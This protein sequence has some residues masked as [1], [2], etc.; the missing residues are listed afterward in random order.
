[1]AKTNIVIKDYTEHFGP[2]LTAKDSV[3][4]SYKF[5]DS[6]QFDQQYEGAP[7]KNILWDA[8]QIRKKTYEDTTAGIWIGVDTDGKAKI[9][10]GDATN[11]FVWN[12]TG[13]IITGNTDFNG[14]FSIVDDGEL[15]VNFNGNYNSGTDTITFNMTD[16]NAFNFFQYVETAGTSGSSY[17]GGWTQT[18]PG[19]ITTGNTVKVDAIITAKY[20]TATT[21]GGVQAIGLG[22]AAALGIYYGSGAPTVSAAKGSL[23]LRSDGSGTNDRAYI[24]TNGS[25]T[26][27][28][29]VTVA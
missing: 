16:R 21:A 18:L 17:F 12:G 8:T 14:Q 7:G 13:L 6:L 3:L 28:A 29:L 26:W 11:S 9:N 2:D 4:N 23:Y 27:T 19:G 5:T 24:N 15:I 10:I 22:T 25:T 1:M 20:T